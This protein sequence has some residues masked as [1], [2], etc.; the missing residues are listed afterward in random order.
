MLIIGFCGYA[1]SG[2]DTA[3]KL[4]LDDSNIRGK[5]QVFSFA[6][7]LRAFAS[8]LNVYFPELD[9][10]YNDV[11]AKYGYEVAKNQFPCIRNHLIAIGHGAREEI[12][13]TIWIDSV[14]Y[15]IQLGNPEIAII[16][17]VRYF[18]EVEYIRKNNGIVIYIE[19]PK[20]EAV[21]QTE[22]DSI[23]EI[24]ARSPIKIIHNDSNFE[25]LHQRI[26]EVLV[27]YSVVSS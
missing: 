16:S 22:K 20:I 10:K 27:N 24:L 23:N 19:R 13:P 3:A 26:L 15:Q 14:H 18:N 2:K 25:I 17:D 7:A 9:M 8:K 11:I 5:K 4:V 6:G 21:H 12:M 1:R